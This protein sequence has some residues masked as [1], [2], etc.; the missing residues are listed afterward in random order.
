MATCFSDLVDYHYLFLVY[1]KL[2]IVGIDSSTQWS[3]FSFWFFQ[4]MILGFCWCGYSL[5]VKVK[6]HGKYLL[7]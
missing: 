6:F 5:D 1:I 2:V 7:Q 4:A 3:A